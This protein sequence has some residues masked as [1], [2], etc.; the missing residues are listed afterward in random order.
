MKIFDAMIS[1]YNLPFTIIML[2]LFLG[3][4][5]IVFKRNASKTWVDF[6][7]AM[8]AILTSIGIFGTFFGIVIALLDFSDN[9]IREQ[10]HVIISGMQTA[11][12]TSVLGIFLSI[13]LKI[14]LIFKNNQNEDVDNINAEELLQRFI[15]Q[16][17]TTDKILTQHEITVKKLDELIN[18]I[19]R[20]GDNSMV[21]QI[22]LMRADFSDNH[23]A[24]YTLFD[25]QT[26]A[27]VYL[28]NIAK[29][30]QQE[31]QAFEQKLW[32]QMEWMNENLAKSATEKIAESLNKALMVLVE[33][34]EKNHEERQVFERKLWQQMH[35]VTESLSK[36]A[37]EQIIES[38]NQVIRDFNDKITEQFGENFKQLNQ[39]VGHLLQW[40]ENYKQQI[41][42]MIAQYELGVKA[43]DLTKNSVAN[44]EQSTSVI[45]NHM[46]ELNAV[47]Q[48]NQTNLNALTNH[49]QAFSDMRENAVQSLPEIQSHI[50]LM[51]DNMQEGSNYV[52]HAFDEVQNTL[53][54]TAQTFAKET[55]NSNNQVK[56]VANMI[57]NWHQDF[58]H[59]LQLLQDNFSET[60]Q[61]MVK[62]QQKSNQ[63]IQHNLEQ[64]SEQSWND[65]AEK[66]EGILSESH[67]GVQQQQNEALKSMGQSLISIT[68]QFTDDYARLVNAMN[69]VINRNGGR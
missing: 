68:R 40:Q 1:G 49:L 20:D 59:S 6:A 34:A 27:L 69:D 54:D 44:I 36:S 8:P 43:I 51:L 24:N 45:P 14:I 5:G 61:N 62:E 33:I 66:I 26:K 25:K 63:T 60:L 52:T 46:N 7:N 23:K 67:K 22:R 37:T 17:N 48:L 55:Q 39:A 2:A 31:K 56:A 29:Q 65:T 11:F 30:N 16:T 50:A 47:I 32:Q 18:A 58:A 28:Y 15:K 13:L 10:I 9:N 19:G 42:Q 38:L 64:I 12:I 57:E 21:G 53:T 35:Q 4:V 3:A 41:E